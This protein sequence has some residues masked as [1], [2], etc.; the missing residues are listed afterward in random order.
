MTLSLII[1]IA[2][3]VLTNIASLVV[4]FFKYN[5][6]IIKLETELQN[7]VECCKSINDMKE[8]LNKLVALSEF[9]I[10]KPSCPR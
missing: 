10:K 3:F 1:T 6:R 4:V 5:N 7:Y 8:D 2:I 9:W